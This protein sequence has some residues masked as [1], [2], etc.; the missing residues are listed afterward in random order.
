MSGRPRGGVVDKEHRC[1]RGPASRRQLDLG[2]ACERPG[3]LT[4]HPDR[5]PVDG[6][7]IRDNPGATGNQVDGGAQDFERRRLNNDLPT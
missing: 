6:D 3:S 2:Q 7:E 1:R 5:V 4:R